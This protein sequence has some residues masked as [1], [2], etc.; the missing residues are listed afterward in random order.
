MWWCL[1]NNF[2]SRSLSCENDILLFWALQTLKHM[3]GTVS[4][5]QDHLFPFIESQMIVFCL[6]YKEAGAWSVATSPTWYAPPCVYLQ[7]QYWCQ[8]SITFQR[9]SCFFLT[10]LCAET[11]CDITNFLI[12]ITQILN[13]SRTREESTKKENTST[14]WKAFQISFTCFSL[15]RASKTTIQ[16]SIPGTPRQKRDLG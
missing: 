9:Y 5:E 8:I 6:K 2:A 3:M 14:F 7:V 15:H 16:N 10:C 11:T 12:S 13:I 1:G 4:F